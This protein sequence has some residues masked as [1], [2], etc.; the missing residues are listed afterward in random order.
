M[1]EQE[2]QSKSSRVPF[3][4]Q[5]NRDFWWTQS[6]SQGIPF[7]PWLP[8]PTSP[9]TFQI[10]ALLTMIGGL[11]KPL[12]DT[13]GAREDQLLLIVL[14]IINVPLCSIIPYLPGQSKH[15][16]SIV[17]SWVFLWP[18]LELRWGYIQLVGQALVSFGLSKLGS[19][20]YARGT[21]TFPWPWIVFFAAMGHLLGIHVHRHM[22]NMSGQ[23]VHTSVLT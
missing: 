1:L 17:L 19:R 11:L 13:L 23:E 21:I 16:F 10:A 8:T 2:K 9:S 3:K 7:L 12:S 20:L 15:L 14:L 6:K 4:K 18:L 22:S 5:D